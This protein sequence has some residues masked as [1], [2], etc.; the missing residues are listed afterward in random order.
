MYKSDAPKSDLSKSNPSK[1]DSSKSDPSKKDPS[2][3]DLSKS[4]PSKSDP[5]KVELSNSDLSKRRALKDHSHAVMQPLKIFAEFAQNLEM[6]KLEKVCNFSI[7]TCFL[8]TF[9]LTF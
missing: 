2:K 6:C 7:S 5:S 1:S 8:Y 9:R 3:K 4:D